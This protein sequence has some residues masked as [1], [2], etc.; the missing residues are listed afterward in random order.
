MQE[1][2]FLEYLN[3]GGTVT[4]GSDM[5]KRMVQM[6]EDAMRIT[7]E[8][9]GS[10]H[11]PEEIRELMSKLTG[12]EIDGSFRLF[13][14]FY[15]EFGKNI[16]IGKNVFIN[17]CCHFQDHGGVYIGDGA[18]IGSHVVL[19]TINHSLVPEKRADNHPAPIHIGKNA[20][21][22]SHVTILPGVSIGDHAVVAAGAVVTTDVPAMSVVGG[23]P[24]KRLKAIPSDSEV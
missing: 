14:P 3:Q 24:A 6:A 2:D 17:C 23:V 7:M 15:T 20:W 1:K 22:G 5:H 19:A 16:H 9:N 8:L 21:I 18:L 10:Y 4:G 11:S 12:T 13:P